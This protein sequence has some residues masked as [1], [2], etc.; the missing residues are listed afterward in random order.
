MRAHFENA[1]RGARKPRSPPRLQAAQAATE[2]PSRIQST[3][4]N[5]PGS[6]AKHAFGQR[7]QSLTHILVVG[8]P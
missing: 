5:D 2:L 4:A 3:G 1:G 8:E 6:S 7:D